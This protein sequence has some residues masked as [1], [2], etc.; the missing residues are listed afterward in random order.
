MKSQIMK[1]GGVRNVVVAFSIIRYFSD[2]GGGGGFPLI[3]KKIPQVFTDNICLILSPIFLKI[4]ILK[5]MFLC[6]CVWGG[7]EH[8][9]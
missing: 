2:F 7:G 1:G 6:V 3:K 8:S 9:V 5:S 4:Y